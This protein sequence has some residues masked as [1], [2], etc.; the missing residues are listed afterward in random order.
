MQIITSV[1]IR[2]S[3]GSSIIYAEI[4]I[5]V[6]VVVIGPIKKIIIYYI[7]SFLSNSTT[8]L[9]MLTLICLNQL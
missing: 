6:K 2:I 1:L 9:P 7:S 5:N 4:D 8:N 3:L